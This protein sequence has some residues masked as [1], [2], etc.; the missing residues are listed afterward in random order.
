MPYFATTVLFI[1]AF[2]EKLNETLTRV[3]WPQFEKHQSHHILS[4]YQDTVKLAASQVMLQPRT[5]LLLCS[6]TILPK[7][8]VG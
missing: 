8:Q 7:T 2:F 4:L 5:P 6:S 1:I 3:Q